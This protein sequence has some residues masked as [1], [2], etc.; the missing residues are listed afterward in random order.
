MHGTRFFLS[1]YDLFEM[2]CQTGGLAAACISIHFHV[3]NEMNW[4]PARSLAASLTSA[5]V[6]AGYNWMARSAV[7]PNSERRQLVK[8]SAVGG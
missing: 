5:S 1:G 2:I 8:F 6:L 4:S 3:A 7:S